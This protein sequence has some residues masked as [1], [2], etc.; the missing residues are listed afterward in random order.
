MIATQ[1]DTKTGTMFVVVELRANAA[2]Y[3]RSHVWL[4]VDSDWYIVVLMILLLLL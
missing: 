4:W 3:V 2:D 1:A